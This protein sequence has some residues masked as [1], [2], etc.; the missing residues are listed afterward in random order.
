[1]KFLEYFEYMDR[2]YGPLD[3]HC[4]HISEECERNCVGLSK[5]RQK[6]QKLNLR[7]GF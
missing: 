7:I 3:V 4:I 5:S 2:E 1:M 6:M